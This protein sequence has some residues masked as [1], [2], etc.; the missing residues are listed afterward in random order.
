MMKKEEEV[1]KLEEEVVTLRIKV[2]K[3]NRN[4][5]ERETSIYSVENVEETPS[6]SLEK[7]NEEETKSCVEVLKE[8]THGQ[9]ESK[10]KEYN[11]DSYSTITTAFRKQR[12]LNHDEDI[13]KREYHDQPRKKFRRTTQQRIS[14]TP[15][16]VNIFYGHYFYCT[17]FGNKVAG[18]I[19]YERNVHT[20]KSY[21]APHDIECYKCHNY[22]NI[23]RDCRRVMD[24]SIKENID[25]IYK[26]V[27]KRK[28]E[29]VKED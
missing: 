19:S 8:R 12:S 9:Q 26:K 6:R 5:E 23:A 24:T 27:W 22:G 14:F 20:I 13:H 2:I 25:I 15:R 1:D 21:V 4:I 11:R 3:I 28:K 16:Y 29:H 7:K 17:N 18:C 10:K